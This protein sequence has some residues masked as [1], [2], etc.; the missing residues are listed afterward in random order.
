MLEV[1]YYNSCVLLSSP[2]ELLVEQN[3]SGL[4]IAVTVES[5]EA[6]GNL[7]CLYVSLC[8]LFGLWHLYLKILG[9]V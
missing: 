9:K 6:W 5:R 8:N 7:S 3:C 1:C 2:M 4:K